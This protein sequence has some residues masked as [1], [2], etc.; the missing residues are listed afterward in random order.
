MSM[1]ISQAP[2]SRSLSSKVSPRHLERWALVYVR[3]STAQQLVRNQESTRLQY[4]L[5]ERALALGWEAG[6]ISVI[7]DDLGKSASS[8]EGRPGFQRLVAEVGLDHVGVILG[9]EMSRFARSCRDWHQ[10]LEICALFGTLIADLDG[11]YDPSNYN[12]R[13]LLGLK[14][15]MSEAELHILKRR[16]LDGRL[17]KAQRGELG[18]PVPIG[19][20]RRPSGEVVKDPD[21][22]ART[23]VETIFEQFAN[24]GTGQRVLRYLTDHGLRIPVRER[25]GLRKGELT[26]KRPTQMTLMGILKHPMYAGAYVF[27]RRPLD[28]RR[29]KPGR[30]GTGKRVASREEWQVFLPDHFPAYISWEQ[31]LRNQDQL[32]ANRPQQMGV[33]GQGRSLVAGLIFCGKCGKRMRSM[34][35]GA[36]VTYICAQA[37]S[38]WGAPICQILSGR[39]LDSEVERQVLE[40]LKPAS[41]EVRMAVATDVEARRVK[42]EVHWTQRLERAKYEA[43]RAQRQFDG[44]EP[45]NR[46]VVRSLERQWEDKL[47]ALR[48]LEE[49]Y[50]R[51]QAVAP[52]YLTR[53]EREAIQRLAEDIPGLWHAPT[54]T[55]AQRKEIARQLIDKVTVAI[56]GESERVKVAIFWAGGHETRLEI[57]RPVAKLSQLSYLED[58]LDRIRVLR[59]E[60]KSSREIADILNSEHWRPAKRRLTFTPEMVRQ[61]SS[62]AGLTQPG[63]RRERIAPTLGPG[64]WTVEGLSAEL[65]IPVS[66]LYGW[67]HR[68]LI[69]TKW[70]E[71]R[72]RRLLFLADAAEVSRLRKLRKSRQHP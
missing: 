44:V 4:A 39:T 66:T 5:R 56:R 51:H 60:D 72:P 47:Q 55:W 69:R 28:K 46:L 53:V 65:G 32:R 35:S 10:L 42:E 11:V 57:Q 63:P 23:A 41:L 52:P 54:T 34:C 40:V 37:K 15:T 14:G 24:Q 6:R 8:V 13:L 45:E 70:S 67:V 29:Q 62:R 31:Y 16:M 9:I 43:D 49:E 21:E 2:S 20:F 59:A 48:Q 30:P 27:G 19:Y 33:P 3:Q 61:L 64:E 58:L 36:G 26:W 25:S 7:D 12:D 17:A 22:Q 68:N 18:M 50:R 38:M 1:A 71:E